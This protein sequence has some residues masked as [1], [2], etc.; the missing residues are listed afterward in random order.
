M[1]ARSINP[2]SMNTI[3]V[4][5]IL[6]A[7]TALA[8]LPAH[9]AIPGMNII[10]LTSPEP[11]A[12]RNFGSTCVLNERY[13][14]VSDA[15][16]PSDLGIINQGRVRVYDPA[17][18]SLLRTL[19]ASHSATVQYFGRKLAIHGHLLLVGC[20]SEQ[21]FLFDLN[22]GKQLRT[23]LRPGPDISSFFGEVMQL[24]DRHAII[25]HPS[26][27]V[28]VYEL[29]SQDPPL[30][31]PPPDPNHIGWF[32]YS[33]Y[34]YEN[35]LLVGHLF[36]ASNKGMVHRF[37]LTTGQ[38]LG[39]HPVLDGQLFDRLGSALAGAGHTAY[40]SNSPNSGPGKAYRITLDGMVGHAFNLDPM[41]GGDRKFHPA[42]LSGNLAAW[43]AGGEVVLS[44]AKTLTPFLTITS[45]DLETNS[46]LG[47]LGLAANRLLISAW[48]DNSAGAEAGAAFLVQTV[49][50]PMPG[51][52]VA[53][54]GEMAPGATD[55]TYHSLT[56]AAIDSNGCV[57]LASSLRG[58]DSNK[59]RDTAVFDDLASKGVL[60]L[61]VKSRDDLG[62][63]LR[64]AS[65]TAPL[66]NNGYALFTARLAGTGV[67]SASNR[68]V[69]RSKG[70]SVLPLL[71]TGQA[72][73]VFGGDPLGSFGTLAQSATTSYFSTVVRLR[74]TSAATDSGLLMAHSNMANLTDG[75]REGQA[76]GITDVDFA[77]FLPRVSHSQGA[78]A[79]TS[80][81]SG[82]TAQNQALFVRAF[83]GAPT[84]AARKGSPASG[85]AGTVFSSFLA[86]NTVHLNHVVFRAKV[87]G[88]GIKP[89]N[90]EGIWQGP[91]AM[92]NLVAR[93]GTQVPG[94][95]AGV[96]WSRFLQVCPQNDRILLRARLRG[97]GIKTS[98]DEVLFLYQENQ[99]FLL[100]YREGETLPGMNGARGGVIRR[101]EAH[102]DGSY[103]LIVSLGKASVATNLALLGGNTFKSTPGSTLRRAELKL[104]K[105]TVMAVSSGGSGARL[106][107]LNFA[108]PL[109]RDASGMGCKGLPSVT[110]Q[111]GTLMR[112]TF[113][114]RSLQ[115]VRLP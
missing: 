19:K 37:D 21:V 115:L 35:I 53:T 52:V 4:S 80:M 23:F 68:M 87:S 83:G 2:H 54:R 63:G 73:P 94:F 47:S 106:T 61:L 113:K 69:L 43:R 10:R 25:S 17:T 40:V 16:I 107:S 20:Y 29:G 32:G 88:I 112:L 62:S 105:G 1:M 58:K 60:D 13:A 90:N 6:F 64:V 110:C 36:D 111:A 26:A 100:L 44:D 102:S 14:V 12:D 50:E 96:V 11:A 31:L 39:S 78:V 86:E 65:V 55:I 98:N 66:M 85:I 9:G 67:T 7:A 97:P 70:T 99:N 28:Y 82:P 101:L 22:T 114:N 93:T 34:G 108:H 57:V 5:R 74:G 103:Q 24:T 109:T 89:T 72:L 76:T 92:P 79:F 91:P 8:L 77:Q 33:L 95:T 48:K 84:L 15:S 46:D 56:A 75:L 71:R 81:V 51:A 42:A 3:L 30:V 18:G 45:A 49:S 38:L 104:R 41:M 59:G 27:A